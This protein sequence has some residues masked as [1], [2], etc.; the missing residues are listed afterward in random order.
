MTTNDTPSQVAPR[1]T[2][3]VRRRAAQEAAKVQEQQEAATL[4]PPRGAEK[5][6]MIEANKAKDLARFGP[7]KASRTKT[8]QAENRAKA[9]LQDRELAA[10]KPSPL[11]R[12][13]PGQQVDARTARLLAKQS[14]RD[15]R[16]NIEKA[17]KAA[18]V[19]VRNTLHGRPGHDRRS[20][21]R[22][23]AQHNALNAKTT[24]AATQ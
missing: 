8:L 6:Q 22:R 2:D 10:P 20:T 12:L 13:E 1:G 17:A 15:E 7:T 4:I 19:A 11:A 18:G 14:D 3:R 21:A 9:L 23:V 5:Q 24:A 16:D